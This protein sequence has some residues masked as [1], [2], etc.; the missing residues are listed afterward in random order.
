MEGAVSVRPTGPRSSGGSFHEKGSTVPENPDVGFL[1]LEFGCS[2]C[3]IGPGEAA[4]CRSDR[5]GISAA[6]WLDAEAGRPADCASL[7]FLST[8]LLSPTTVTHWRPRRV[9]TPMSSRS[10]ICRKEKSLIAWRF[11]R[12]GSAWRR[13]QPA[14]GCGGPAVAAMRCTR[15]G[16]RM[17]GS[18]A[19]EVRRPNGRP[20]R[21]A[22]RATSRRHRAR[23][24]PEGSLFTRRRCR[25]DLGPRSCG[26]EG[27][28]V[29]AGRHAALRRRAFTW[30]QSIV[31]IRLG[32]PGRSSRRPRRPPHGGADRRR[33]A[34]Q[35][36]RR[37]PDR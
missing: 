9:T 24:G 8:S 34:S 20:R 25:N 11:R 3:L 27:T 18:L 37:L 36:D 17:A 23:P 29:S 19:W 4:L 35:P 16:L 10:S 14:T 22:S 12:A 2:R 15:F 30:R 1:G 6:E 28:A 32:W 7:T 31:R 21:K 5:A 26:P 33:R 13:M